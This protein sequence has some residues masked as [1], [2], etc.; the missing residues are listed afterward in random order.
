ME[1]DRI[2]NHARSSFRALVQLERDRRGE[3][4]VRRFDTGKTKYE[5]ES[6]QMHVTQAIRP[7]NIRRYGTGETSETGETSV[8][9]ER[10]MFEIS[11]LRTRGGRVCLWCGWWISMHDARSD[12]SSKVEPEAM[13]ERIDLLSG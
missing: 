5:A 13:K 1:G 2:N 8:A 7:H 12:L 3:R 6:D 9:E 4:F 11:P 10:E